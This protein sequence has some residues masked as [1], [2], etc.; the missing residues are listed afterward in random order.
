[1]N[2]RVHDWTGT[3]AVNYAAVVL[4]GHRFYNADVIQNYRT[5]KSDK[6]PEGQIPNFSQVI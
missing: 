6:Y 4:G 2:R 3:D 5:L 1:M